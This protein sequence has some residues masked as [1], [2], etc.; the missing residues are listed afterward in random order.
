M[1]IISSL[2]YTSHGYRP[3]EIGRG[4]RQGSIVSPYLFNIFAEDTVHS[5]TSKFEGGVKIGGERRNNMRFADD[6]ALMCVAAKK[7]CWTS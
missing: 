2:L 7:N 5:V 3:F 1:L 4:V 6:T